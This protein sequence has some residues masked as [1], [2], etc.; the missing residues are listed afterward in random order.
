MDQYLNDGLLG[1]IG[2]R[3]ALSPIMPEQRSITFQPVQKIHCGWVDKVK[4]TS[5]G[6]YVENWIWII[7]ENSQKKKKNA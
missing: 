4:G 3:D 2:H 5:I 6:W 1:V 7:L